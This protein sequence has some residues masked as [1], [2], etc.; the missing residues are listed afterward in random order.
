M[1][2]TVAD[3]VSRGRYALLLPGA[4]SQL[5]AM[6]HRLCRSFPVAREVLQR[7][8]EAAGLDLE[9]L[10]REGKP[11]ELA[12]AEV[13]HP[14][15][16]ATG[17]AAAAALRA[18]LGHR[19]APPAFVGG[20]SLGHFGALV[21]AGCLDR[22]DALRLVARRARLMGEQTRSRPALMASVGGV[23]P[24]RVAAWCDACPEGLGVVVPACFNGPRQTVVSGDAA[25]VRWVGARA[26][27]E[28]AG[29]D[30]VRVRELAAGVASHS[31]LM[32]PVQR[33]LAPRLAAVPLARPAVPVLLNSTGR[34][35]RDTGEI[36]ADLLEQL[37][38]PVRWTDAMR[39]LVAAGVTTV[40][41][42]GPGQVLARAAALHPELEAVA[43]NA[44]RPLEKAVPSP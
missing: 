16:V 19:W 29:D 30:G 32:E 31:P 2:T 11:A 42:T 5:P 13:S 4:G 8:G 37:S 38:V 40:L 36:R 41:D 26:A 3:A 44:L 24:E 18:H 1:T 23:P 22:D 28:G 7:A 6:A 10:C 39:T 21:E 17:L 27:E 14:A 15:I 35:T 33:A 34:A 25:A 9:R 43:L 12:A 20:H